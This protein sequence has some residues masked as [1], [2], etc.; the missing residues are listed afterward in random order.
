MGIVWMIRMICQYMRQGQY[1]GEAWIY[2]HDEVIAV[3]RE[4]A[5]KL[6]SS[7]D[8][9]F[10]GKRL[11]METVSDGEERLLLGR[12]TAFL[13]SGLQ[14]QNSMVSVWT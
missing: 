12:K 1:Q 10:I 11:H 6:L 4:L 5:E 3:L 2:G 7:K 8:T 13:I 9:R 14:R